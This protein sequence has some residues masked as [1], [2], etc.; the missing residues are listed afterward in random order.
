MHPLHHLLLSSMKIP[1]VLKIRLAYQYRDIVVSILIYTSTLILTVLI[2]WVIPSMVFRYRCILECRSIMIFLKL[3]TIWI[4]NNMHSIYLSLLKCI[5]GI[6]EIENTALTLTIY[7]VEFQCAKSSS[8]KEPNNFL[9]HTHCTM[10]IV[11]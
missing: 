11:L 5:P 6:V 2:S 4:I 7:N 8:W 9:L 3:F 10:S 1:F